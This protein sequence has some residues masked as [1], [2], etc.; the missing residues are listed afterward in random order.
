ML[1]LEIGYVMLGP[2]P[3]MVCI[4]DP[5]VSNATGDPPGLDDSLILLELLYT[6]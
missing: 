6:T 5:V 3:S 1:L 2:A 4:P